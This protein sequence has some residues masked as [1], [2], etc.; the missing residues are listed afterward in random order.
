[1]DLSLTKSTEIHE[2]LR[3]QFRAEW[4]NVANHT[5][6]MTPNAVVLSSA[7]VY[8]PTAGV[9]TATSTTSR[10]LQFGLKLLF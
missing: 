5:N 1:V 2:R 7:T 4:F 8:S 10:Q 9:L 3:A 6:F